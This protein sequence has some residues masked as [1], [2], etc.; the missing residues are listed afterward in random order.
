MSYFDTYKSRLLSQGNSSAESIINSTKQV[1]N[2]SFDTSLSAKSVLIDG[3]STT[4]IVNQGDTSEEKSMLLKPDSVIDN[5][6]VVIIDSLNYLVVDFEVNEVYPTA[7]LKLCN[8]TF[9]IQSDKTKVLIGNDPITGRPIYEEVEG[10]IVYEPCI[11]E[12]KY[13][14]NNASE[15]LP[16]PNGDLSVTIKYRADESLK[17]NYEFAMYGN[18]YK[19]SDFDLTKVINDKGIMRIIAERAV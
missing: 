3:V 6:T 9:P 13:P 19:V 14:A 2:N 17:V 18:Q 8:S 4:T 1:I 5:G 10:A 16:L 11:V 7:Q 12:T 15:Q